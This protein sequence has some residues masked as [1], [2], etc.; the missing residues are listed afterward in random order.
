MIN[1][2]FY[3][4]RDEHPELEHYSSSHGGQWH[5]EFCLVILSDGSIKTTRFT[6]DSSDKERF[7]ENAWTGTWREMSTF[8]WCPVRYWVYLKD[9][10]KIERESR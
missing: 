7:D 4:V 8:G 6:L 5:S 2:P 3:D 10:R 1:I 9:I